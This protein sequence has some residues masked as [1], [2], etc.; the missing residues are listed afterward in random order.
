MIQIIIPMES[1]NNTKFIEFLSEHIANI[2]HT[3]KEVK[4][5]TFVDFICINHCGLIILANKVATF[6]NLCVV[7][8]YIKNTSFV[9]LNN[10]QSAHLL[11][12]KSYLKILKI[13]YFI[14]GINMPINLSVVEFIIKNTYIFNNIHI[15]SKL[16]I[17]KVSSKSDIAIIWIYI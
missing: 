10:I 3:F 7:K 15:T 17:I 16:C 12:S 11:Q 1:N 8:N 13:P 4:S 9:D 2:N 14:E 5:N 6:S